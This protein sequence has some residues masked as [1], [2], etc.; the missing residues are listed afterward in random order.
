MSGTL[1]LQILSSFL[2]SVLPRSHCGTLSPV[3][4]V[5]RY[6]AELNCTKFNRPRSTQVQFRTAPTAVYAG[7][8][9]SWNSSI[10]VGG[11][12]IRKF[13]SISQ[14]GDFRSTTNCLSLEDKNSGL[15]A[16]IT[17]SFLYVDNQ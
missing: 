3:V 17:T 4:V 2:M 13:G 7:G 8:E 5:L 11:A 12:V 6:L 14:F 1:P 10:E 15:V 9:N 16:I